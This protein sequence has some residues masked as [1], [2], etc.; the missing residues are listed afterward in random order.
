MDTP[1]PEILISN[2]QGSEVEGNQ[3][4]DALIINI[5]TDWFHGICRCWAGCRKVETV[6]GKGVNADRIAADTLTGFKL[7]V[8]TQL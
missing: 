2:L 6:R 3:D 8:T 7:P 5:R 4:T 1:A